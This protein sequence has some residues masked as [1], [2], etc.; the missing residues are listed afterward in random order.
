MS[1]ATDRPAKRGGL[2]E[3]IKVVVEALILAVLF[4][5]FLFQPF[6]IESGSMKE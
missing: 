3:T 5:T 1:I 4:R 2:G 6:Y